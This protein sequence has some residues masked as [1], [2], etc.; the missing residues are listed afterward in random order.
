MSF[1]AAAMVGF[2][3]RDVHVIRDEDT[4]EMATSSRLL[5]KAQFAPLKFLGV[6]GTI[7]AAD[8]RMRDIGLESVLGV[9]YGGGVRLRVFPWFWED[10]GFLNVELD[11]QIAAL[12]TR[13]GNADL[14]AFGDDDVRVEYWEYQ[15]SLLVS[16]RFEVF[17]P[18]LAVCYNRSGVQFAPGGSLNAR[19]DFPWGALVGLEYFVTPQ[20]FFT[21]EVHIFTENSIYVGAGFAY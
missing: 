7:G 4:G 14:K 6:Y 21:A 12:S 9:W 2:A 15:A 20:V 10:K 8:W 17:V 5:V 13:S 3:F 18:Y 11:G 19:P 16:K 1:S